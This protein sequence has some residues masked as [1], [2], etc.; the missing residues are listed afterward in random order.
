MSHPLLA[1]LNPA[2]ARAVSGSAPHHLVLAGAGSGKTR[3]LVHRV[4]WLTSEQ[5]VH[6]SQVLAV[7]F[8]NKAAKEMRE[9]LE[10]LVPGFA[11]AWV[12]TFHGLAHRWLRLHPVEAGLP[13]NFQ[14][15]DMDDQKKLVKAI[16]KDENLD[17]ETFDP[18]VVAGWIGVQKDAGRWPADVQPKDVLEQTMKEVFEIYQ[19]RCAKA[20]FVDFA[21]LLL[22][23]KLLFEQAPVLLQHYQARF[24]HILVDEFQ[25]TNKVQYDLIRQLSGGGASVFIVGD[26]DQSIYGWRGAEV[27]NMLR[28]Q[29]EFPDVALVK[30]E[31]NYRSTGNILKA[32]NRIIAKNPGRIGKNLHTQ[33]PDGGKVLVREC[34][35]EVD[36]ARHVVAQ[37]KAWATRPGGLSGCAVL[38]RANAQSRALEEQLLANGLPYRI[39][40]GLKFFERAEIKDAMAYLR[41]LASRRDDVAFERVVNV[42]A[43]GL[44][45]KSIEKIRALARMQGGSLWDAAHQ[46][47]LREDITG[48]AAK[49]L[50]AFLDLFDRWQGLE[51]LSLEDLTH[52][53]LLDSGL[54]EHHEKE[55]RKDAGKDKSSRLENLDELVSVVARFREARLA[56]AEP[57]DLLAFMAH[58][59]LE[60][61]EQ[62]AGNAAPEEDCVQ[63]MTIHTAKGLEFPLVCLVG[64]EDGL[65]PTARSLEDQD[66]LEEERRLAYVAITR[67]MHKLVIC[68]ARSRRLYGQWQTFPASRFVKDLPVEVIEKTSAPSQSAGHVGATRQSSWRQW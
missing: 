19:D 24:K 64:W 30:L 40:G 12:G 6:P 68:Y 25:D 7:T 43:R 42:P 31:E 62:G 13:E 53:I 1:S 59:A 26:D 29:E 45:G 33:E 21:E 35:D 48:K 20:G 46:A 56:A 66:V 67:A 55:A 3:V 8:T 34:A 36:E 51:L 17:E 49:S 22:R 2:Q 41:L 9:R 37:I 63:L 5:G 39:Y 18:K 50:Q 60:A 61:G 57:A 10:R 44:G 47:L 16:I 11:G 23:L 52:E 27:E 65:F 32:A 14:I 4:A 58:A 38:Y 28:F 54:R 15:L